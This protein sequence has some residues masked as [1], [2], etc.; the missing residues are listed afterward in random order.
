MLQ[1]KTTEDVSAYTEIVAREHASHN[2][3][4]WMLSQKQKENGDGLAGWLSGAK[5]TSHFGFCF[6]LCL[7]KL[8]ETE[9]LSTGFNSN[10]NIDTV[11][12][13]SCGWGA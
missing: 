6:S 3:S 12:G 4:C 5:L 10:L 7:P 11:L 2:H 8:Q 9:Q 13:L 1:N